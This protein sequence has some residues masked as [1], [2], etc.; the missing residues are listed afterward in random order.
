MGTCASQPPQPLLQSYGPGSASPEHVVTIRGSSKVPE[1][2][3]RISE[4]LQSGR[5]AGRNFQNRVALPMALTAGLVLV[6]LLVMT[7]FNAEACAHEAKSDAAQC[8]LSA[9]FVPLMGTP[10]VAIVLLLTVL[11]TQT[12]LV[13]I[14]G[15]VAVMLD[16]G[17]GTM[18]AVDLSLALYNS[19][20]LSKGSC[21]DIFTHEQQSCVQMSALVVGFFT[22]FYIGVTGS[23]KLARMMHTTLQARARLEQVWLLLGTDF[24]I[25]GLV[26][27]PGLLLKG[28]ING[29]LSLED[30]IMLVGVVQL[31]SYGF[32]MRSRKFRVRIHSFLA[33]R[34]QAVTTAVGIAAM[35]GDSEPEMVQAL[36]IALFRAVPLDRVTREAMALSKPDSELHELS[37]HAMLA[38][39][40]A[41]VSH[42]WIDD[43]DAKWFQLQAWRTEFVSINGREP[44]VWIDKYCIHAHDV[45][46]SLKCLPVWI[47]GCNQ[48][49]ALVG[50]SY[51]TRLWCL[52]E[53][54][55][56]DMMG[57]AAENMTV[58]PFG[59][60]KAHSLTGKES[61]AAK[62]VDVRQAL[63]SSPRDKELLISII[64]AG[65]GVDGFNAWFNTRIGHLAERTLLPRFQTR[66]GST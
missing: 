13:R 5:A 48:M 22:W 41:F 2:K 6:A 57:G 21:A 46:N 14:A 19:P 60:S 28:L 63:C 66:R 52:L 12:E 32:M 3:Q 11:P 55:T 38:G 25:G 7:F 44:L 20:D 56:Y 62:D 58:L 36:A 17:V 23:Y 43:A 33:S 39:V 50:K 16:L 4:R 9:Q 18:M 45:E 31:A 54:F 26:P 59:D 24:L 61:A 51:H 53:L 1:S 27:L 29:S 42:S 49:V 10:S 47:A 65:V 34:A 35:I 30:T 40:D 15:W 8:G 64:E 37:E